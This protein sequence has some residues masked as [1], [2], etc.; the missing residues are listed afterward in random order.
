MKK[1]IIRP[2]KEFEDGAYR[3]V[4]HVEFNSKDIA[5]TSESAALHEA[6]FLFDWVAFEHYHGESDA[7]DLGIVR[8]DMVKDLICGKEAKVET[9]IASY[10]GKQV[11]AL[12]LSKWGLK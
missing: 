10:Y 1:I 11:T 5:F 3:V 7:E 12:G 8:I 6:H 2:V 4:W 9:I